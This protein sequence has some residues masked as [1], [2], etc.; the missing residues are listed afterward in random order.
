[1]SQRAENFVAVGVVRLKRREGQI[2]RAGDGA[3]LEPLRQARVDQQTC[4]ASDIGFQKTDDLKLA[5]GLTS[6]CFKVGVLLVDECFWVLV[7]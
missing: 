4:A 5:K 7:T 3:F 2:D 6:I 1:M